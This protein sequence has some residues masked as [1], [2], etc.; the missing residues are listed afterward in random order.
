MTLR[1]GKSK[2]SPW[3]S[4]RL[5]AEHRD[6][7]AHRV[8]PHLALVAEAAVERMQLGVGRR[9]RRCPSS[10]RPWL[11]R[12]SVDTRSATRAGWLVVSWMMP[13]PSRM[14]LRALARRG[15][16]HLG[17]RGVRVLLE[18]VVLDLPG[19]VVA[20]PVGQLD[21]VERLAAA[22]G[23]RCPRPTA[24][25][26]GARRR[27]RTSRFVVFLARVNDGRYAT[28]P[29]PLLSPT[30]SSQPESEHPAL[31]P[32]SPWARP[33]GGRSSVRAPAPRGCSGGRDP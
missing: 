18:E 32:S 12:S 10:T 26:A 23:T 17:R 9:P 15:E 1:S 14:L 8:L 20:E 5:V 22:A 7:R 27:S 24:A 29:A 28:C 33:S 31:T 30:S 4:T 21:L 2:Y 3:Y 19:V 13:W 25:A 11:T 16:E 6:Q